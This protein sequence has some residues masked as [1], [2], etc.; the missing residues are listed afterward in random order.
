MQRLIRRITLFVLFTCPVFAQVKSSALPPSETTPPVESR[1]ASSTTDSPSKLP[2]RR[3]VLY[4]NGIGFFEHLGSVRGSQNVHIDFTSAQLNDVLKSLTVLDLSGGRITGVDYN[5]EAPLARRLATLRLALGEKPTQSE[6]L[7]ALRGARIEVRSG[8]APAVF[9]KLLSIER[10]TRSSTT[11][12]VETEEISL[13]TDAGE[14]RSVDL[15]PAT[16][17]R[18]LDDDLKLEVSRYLGLVAAARDQDV[19]R[20][21]IS[22]TGAGERN[23]YVSY[24]SEVPVW[25]TTYR[26]VLPSNA[27]KKPLLQGWAIVDNTVGEDWSNVELSLVAGAPHSFIQQLSEPYYSRRPVVPLPESIQL[28]P[29]THAG[30]LSGGNGRL[31]GIITDASGAVVAG[32]TVRLLDDSGA[33]VTTTTTDGSGNYSF[34]GLPVGN[35]RLEEEQ[36][37]FKKNVI[38][39][40]NVAPGENQLDSTL[41]VGTVSSLVEVSAANTTVNTES[42]EVSS[43]TGGIS[44][45]GVA[46]RVHITTRSG[47]NGSQPYIAGL[48]MSGREFNSLALMSPGAVDAARQ[49]TAPGAQGQDLGDL[50]EYKLKDRVTLKK[51][52]SALVP[53]AQT[54]IDAEK[55]SLWS[56]ASGS[57]RPLR[58]LWIKNTS[59]L[60]FDGGSFSVLEKEVFAGEGLTDPIKPG[61]RRLLSYATDLGLLVEATQNGD[62]MRITQVKIS[63]GVMTQSS[64]LHQRTLYTVRN[65]DE[66]LRTLVIE[67]PARVGDTLAKGTREPEERAPGTYRFKL[68]VPAKATA[69]LP[70]EEVRIQQTNFQLTDLNG[71]QIALFIKN[72][73]V[74]PAVADVLKKIASQKAAVATLEEE[75][76]N[77]QKDIDR[78]VADQARLRENMKALKGSAEE[79]ALLQ[80]Y[81]RELDQQETQLESLRKTIQDTEAQRDK[82][83]SELEAMIANLDLDVTM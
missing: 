1:N 61:E 58:A 24:I 10:K 8:T 32:T 79:K 6:F 41:Q 11:F 7:G 76:E 13:I 66:A 60:T 70:V 75:M 67:H 73:T 47:A 78:I 56:G 54:D 74:T 18:I 77:R 49:M 51:N 33:V 37:G 28:S 22:T 68:E 9:G 71:E 30:S 4:K 65:Q 20:V 63:K 43:D 50:F 39:Q 57:G 12:T 27:D 46:N 23:L 16:S 69:S 83:N 52:Q 3:V 29:Q 45:P 59:P 14:V 62:P 35:Y 31:S 15:N 64:E 21:S 72:G 55:V 25:K 81:T 36:R 5:S 17:I 19:R 80:R 48:P 34:A 38:S 42:A 40:I 82:A 2:V 53:I 44:T 26:I